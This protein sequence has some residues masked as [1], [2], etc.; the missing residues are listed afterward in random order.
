[1]KHQKKS[2]Y[3]KRL[4]P[5]YI[6]FFLFVVGGV[7]LALFWPT[8]VVKQLENRPYS[9]VICDRNGKP[10][11]IIALEEGLMRQYCYSQNLSERVRKIFLTSEDRYF[12]YHFGF[13]AVS[14]FRATYYNLRYRRVI[15]GASTITMQLARLVFPHPKNYRGK[16]QELLDAI[17]LEFWFSKE[18]IFTAWMSNLT[19]GQNVE[20]I[21]SAAWRFFGVPAGA[22]TTEEAAL[23][24]IIPRSPMAYHPQHHPDVLKGKMLDL[25]KQC[26]L[27]YFEDNVDETIRKA[28]M[29][30][31]DES[32]KPKRIFLAPHFCQ[33]IEGKL[34]VL[35]PTL[36]TSGAKFISTL[37]D[38]QQN[39]LQTQIKKEVRIAQKARVSN[40]AGLVLSVQTGEILAYVGSS[41]F[42]DQKNQGQNNGVSALNQPGS[43]LKPFLYELAFERGVTLSSVLPD[44]PLAFGTKEIYQPQNFN[45]RFSGPIR[46]RE[47]LASSLNVPAVYL[48]EQVGVQNFAKRLEELGYQSLATQ[49]EHLGVGLAL[50]NARVSLMELVRSYG[51]LANEG[52]LMPLK[53]LTDIRYPQTAS[54][55][56]INRW[57]KKAFPLF[58]GEGKSVMDS[59]AVHLV[60]KTLSEQSHR[61]RGFGHNFQFPSQFSLLL[62]TG[63]SNQFNHLWAVG[64][65]CDLVTGVWMGNFS[66][67]TAQ[68]VTGSSLAAKVVI[69]HLTHHTVENRFFSTPAELVQEKICVLSGMKAGSHCL[70]TIDEH[71]IEGTQPQACNFHTESGLHLPP[72]YH[73]WA[74]QHEVQFAHTKGNLLEL[75]EPIDR[76]VYF[77]SSKQKERSLLIPVS[78]GCDED[79]EVTFQVDNQILWKGKGSHCQ[80]YSF[81]VGEHHL[82]LFSQN[83]LIKEIYFEVK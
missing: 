77:L 50:G 62:K 9:S 78:W 25:L 4:K 40:G 52:K 29:A 79:Q 60:V 8:A 56:N 59:L 2:F 48:L 17:K 65:S 11:R 61:V 6:G 16:L 14:L 33:W 68:G 73:Q 72:I 83:Q 81:G 55:K 24:A 5:L 34:K 19:F 13:N 1:M 47:A 35:D 71:F 64:A 26:S 76:A 41:D 20:G 39:F 30:L 12:P 42:F 80:S 45:N 67:A 75:F 69:Q 57:K 10:L 22:L 43:T 70:Q 44:V 38:S 37:E 18:E 32:Q 23:L 82:Q 49:K 63:T 58:G 54:K 53:S 74:N 7:F 3:Q 51:A 36:L 15:S 28:A 21:E 31:S 46:A 66:G 27:S